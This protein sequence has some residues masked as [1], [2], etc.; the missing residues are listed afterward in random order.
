MYWTATFLG[1]D[2][3]HV[4]HWLHCPLICL[5]VLLPLNAHGSGRQAIAVIRGKISQG[6]GSLKIPGV[7][8][9]FTWG[10]LDERILR[11]SL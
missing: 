10:L 9:K 2:F 6:K 3:M 11:S 4:T 1:K 8:K 7:W 5:S